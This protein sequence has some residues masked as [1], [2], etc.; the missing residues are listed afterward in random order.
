MTRLPFGGAL[1]SGSEQFG[2]QGGDELGGR[3]EGRHVLV[4]QS[5]DGDQRFKFGALLTGVCLHYL[6]GL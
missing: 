5:G 1:A 4:Q 2:T 6:A 3:V